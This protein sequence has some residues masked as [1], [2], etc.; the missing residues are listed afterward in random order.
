[1]AYTP[2]IAQ[3]KNKDELNKEQRAQVDRVFYEAQLAR[4]LNDPTKSLEL[5]QQVL[6]LDKNNDAAYYEVGNIYFDGNYKDKA[7]PY[8]LEAARIDPK[9]IWYKKALAEAYLA[10]NKNKDAIQV[11]D[12]MIKADKENL[13]LKFEKAMLLTLMS[14][15]DNALKTYQEIEK[16]LG[17]TPE[18]SIQ[19]QQI[20]IRQNNIDKAAA[21][22][23]KLIALYPDEISY[24]GILAN[25]YD[26][27]NMPDKA[28][29]CYQEILKKE[30]HNGIANFALGIIAQ[31]KNENQKYMD[32]MRV[33][34]ADKQM[35][36]DTKIAHIAPML[37]AVIK[38]EEPITSHALELASLL[39]AA[40]PQNAKSHALYGDLFYQ[41]D[42]NQEALI[43]YKKAAELDNSILHVWTQI[44]IIEAEEG[45]HD[46]MYKDS[47]LA[48]ELFPNSAFINYFTGLAMYQK[49]DYKPA[50]T[51]LENAVMMGSENNEL[52]VEVY[53]IL[54]E[55]YH[56]INEH[57]KSDANF[58]KALLIDPNNILIKNNYAYF[59]SLRK[60]NLDKAEKLIKEVLAAEP[61]N[62]SYLDTYAWVLY[63]MKK[64]T[65]AKSYIDKA[66]TGE[67]RISAEVLEHA[68]DIYFKLNDPSKAT[69]YWNRAQQAGGNS[70]I[71]L[72]KIKTGKLE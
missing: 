16:E 34:F 12:D 50:I 43:S 18:I 6:V 36:I 5:F 29:S 23:N 31:R 26:A 32:Y 27:N 15:Y 64:Y 70:D 59:L 2:S 72:Q 13:D 57:N 3:K 33:A 35:D 4:I 11:Y 58:E 65:E 9:N 10:N 20:Y 25:M 7:L 61:N 63:E 60:V 42:K 53:R 69:L 1:M 51:V 21:E 14:E 17:T 8:Y 28:I 30:P 71:L 38:N 48:L 68:G 62:I 47:Q 37:S 56:S 46:E 54:A 44:L 67:G 40:H 66:I 49:K 52:M 19:K 55:T 41:Q 24:W 45:M 39:L 22:I